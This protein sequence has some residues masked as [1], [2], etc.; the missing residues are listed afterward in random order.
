MIRDNTT[1]TPPVQGQAFG[2]TKDVSGNTVYVISIKELCDL[3]SKAIELF[4][5]DIDI[6]VPNSKKGKTFQK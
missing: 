5:K 4:K 2:I 1:I 3:C 6:V